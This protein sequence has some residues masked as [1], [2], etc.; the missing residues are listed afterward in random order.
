MINFL[1]NII[2]MSEIYTEEYSQ[3]SVSGIKYS[4][5][6]MKLALYVNYIT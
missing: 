4:T 1:F 6:Y 3:Y 5:R 2:I